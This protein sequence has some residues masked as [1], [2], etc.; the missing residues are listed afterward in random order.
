MFVCGLSLIIKL[1]KAQD[2][3]YLCGKA[4]DI[5]RIRINN[6][7]GQDSKA[8]GYPLLARTPTSVVFAEAPAAVPREDLAAVAVEAAV[9]HR[10][11][12]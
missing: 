10:R 1:S 8:A 5:E 9:A 12:L 4:Q 7:A 11:V 6:P 2:Q 3:Y